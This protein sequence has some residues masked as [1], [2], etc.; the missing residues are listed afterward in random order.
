MV[1]AAS[2]TPQCTIAIRSRIAAGWNATARFNSS[3][4][5]GASSIAKD[6]LPAMLENKIEKCPRCDPTSTNVELVRTKLSSKNVIE[7]S[8]QPL[9]HLS[10]DSYE[11][12]VWCTGDLIES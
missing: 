8:C 7:G 5:D 11:T 12:I 3:K 10:G 2:D 9:C 4:F 1:S 6:L